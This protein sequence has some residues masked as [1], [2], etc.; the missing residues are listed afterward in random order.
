M[1]QFSHVSIDMDTHYATLQE[2]E[3]DDIDSNL[4]KSMSFNPLPTDVCL[5]DFRRGNC[6]D[7]YIM[8]IYF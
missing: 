3:V 5:Y 6:S 7:G 1:K 8:I 2:E 4:S